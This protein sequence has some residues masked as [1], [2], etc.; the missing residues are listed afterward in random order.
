MPVDFDVAEGFKAQ[1]GRRNSLERCLAPYAADDA[2]SRGLPLPL[3]RKGDQLAVVWRKWFADNHVKIAP[4][5]AE[6]A[7]H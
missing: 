4:G 6:P 2:N 1:L 3:V 5:S 7:K